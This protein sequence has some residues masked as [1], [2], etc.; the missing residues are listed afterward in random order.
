M[1]PY[2]VDADRLWT[3]LM[4]MAEIGATPGGGNTR[5][6]LTDEDRQARDLFRSWCEAAGLSVTID[7]LGSMFARRE[8]RNP[9]R[10]PILLGSHLDTQPMGGRFDGILGVLGALEV[11]R[12]MN[13]HGLVTEAP[14]EI[15]NWTDEEGCRFT[16]TLMP[17]GV[18]AGTLRLEDVL[19]ATDR[20]GKRFGD[21]LERIGYRGEDFP[22]EG[23]QIG[24]YLEL[25]IEQGPV[26]E[27]E[28][29]TIG[30][31]TGGFGLEWFDIVIEGF[32]V[33]AGTTPMEHRRDALAA[34]ADLITRLIAMGRERPD[35]RV[36]IGELHVTPGSRNIVPA[37]VLFTV[38]LRNP[39]ASDLACM[40]E[41]ARS[42]MQA[43]QEAHPGCP[44][45]IESFINSPVTRFDPGM[46]AKV[47]SA[48]AALGLS[49]RDIVSGATHDAIHMA[50]LTPT[51][52]IFVPS[53]DGIS[54]NE[55]EFTSKEHC[56]AGANVLLEAALLC[57]D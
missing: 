30:V 56:A 19:S 15:V 26:L 43:V 39:D 11:I 6:A 53:K 25:H 7:R 42:A 3:S 24:G 27:S 41:Q 49:H 2:R 38:D 14:I 33:H 37:K 8:G 48:A 4:A 40:H 35:R 31:V 20:D 55:T 36:T 29:T 34:A 52:M 28:G 12:T 9:K 51:A 22:G 13:D 47:R 5:L 32:A 44:I 46:I 16:P 10:P 50:A 45:R 17:S 23:R 57:A 18:T 54:H 21:E 1:R